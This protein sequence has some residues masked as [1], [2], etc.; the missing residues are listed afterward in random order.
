[1]VW[2]NDFTFLG[3]D[4]DLRWVAKVMEQRYEIKVR[5]M[6]GPDAGD[7]KEVR[8]LSRLVRWEKDRIVYEGGEKHSQVVIREMGLEEGSKGFDIPVMTGKEDTKGED[9]DAAGIDTCRHTGCGGMRIGIPSS[10]LGAPPF[11][12]ASI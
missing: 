9:L 7:D 3:R 4:V 2:G 8:I 12:D 1:M 11:Y 10:R 6:L 5:A